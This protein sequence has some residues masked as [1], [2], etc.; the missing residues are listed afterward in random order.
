VSAEAL[1]AR[2]PD[3]ATVRRWAV[4][5]AAAD[6][7]LIDRP[8]YRY[9][10]F[11]PTWAAGEE[12]ARM[13]DGSGNE[14]SI[15][16]SAAGAWLRGFD[17]ESPL[18]P[19]GRDPVEPW[20]GLLDAVPEPLRPLAEE[21]AWRLDGVTQVTV[22]LWR[23]AGDERWHAGR[24][25]DVPAEDLAGLGDPDGSDWLF[26]QL[27][28]D[29]SSYAAYAEEYLERPV[30]RALLDRVF[31]H[32]PLTVADLRAAVPGRDPDEVARDLRAVGYP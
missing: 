21:Q 31:A 24:A 28:G 20:P 23:E 2:L 19:W 18:S 13:S 27:D 4:A 15:A 14:W 25:E 22:S 1:A 30:D 17:H 7:L 32:E 11:D 5:L 29:P 8:G 16:F 3:L 12:V 9:F 10:C 6:V 26:A